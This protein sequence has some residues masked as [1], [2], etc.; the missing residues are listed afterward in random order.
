MDIIT[1]QAPADIDLK[2]VDTHPAKTKVIFFDGE[3]ETT[4]T[5]QYGEVALNTPL[6][7]NNT[8]F[9]DEYEV[10]FVDRTGIIYCTVPQDRF[11]ELFDERPKIRDI[12]EARLERLAPPCKPSDVT[13]RDIIAK[14]ST[15][16]IR[17]IKNDIENAKDLIRRKRRQIKSKQE[18]IEEMLLEVK[19]LEENRLDP[20]EEFPELDGYE[21]IYGSQQRYIVAK[22]TPITLENGE[23]IA[24]IYLRLKHGFTD[25]VKAYP[26]EDSHPHIREDRKVFWSNDIND[27]LAELMAQLSYESVLKVAR[28]GLTEYRPEED[29]R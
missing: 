22:T 12:F 4:S 28:H 21:R 29:I 15:S 17:G 20:P 16:E 10:L 11:R 3:G 19:I 2:E 5:N 23:E 8:T 25:S 27:A 9:P 24:P 7:G 26:T 6:G 13:Y 18:D 14:R 1:S